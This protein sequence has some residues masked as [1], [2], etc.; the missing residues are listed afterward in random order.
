MVEL[1]ELTEKI[2]LGKVDTAVPVKGN[3]EVATLAKALDRMRESVKIAAEL[4]G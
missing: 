2:S 3:D 4:L 1:T